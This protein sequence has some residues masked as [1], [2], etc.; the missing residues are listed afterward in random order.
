MSYNMYI[1]PGYSFQNVLSNSKIIVLYVKKL[2]SYVKNS[3]VSVSYGGQVVYHYVVLT[4]NV[5]S[6]LV[7]KE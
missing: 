5:I 1:R 2:K 3:C 6:A 7:G 4:F